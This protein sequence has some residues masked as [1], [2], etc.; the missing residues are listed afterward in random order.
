VSNWNL[1]S[2]TIGYSSTP[3]GGIGADFGYAWPGARF[4]SGVLANST[5]AGIK[6]QAGLSIGASIFGLL[7]YTAAKDC[8]NIK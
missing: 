6:V 7:T 4:G 5:E 1:V 8:G 2:A 3:P